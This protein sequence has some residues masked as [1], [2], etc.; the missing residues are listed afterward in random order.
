MQAEMQETRLGHNESTE[1]SPFR[2][3]KIE[4]E[5]FESK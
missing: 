4:T 2:K 3:K 5:G 1:Q